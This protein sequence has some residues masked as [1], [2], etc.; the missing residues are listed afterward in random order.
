MLTMLTAL[1]ISG[2]AIYYS[3]AGLVAIFA[4]AAIPII[5]MGGILEVSKLVSAVWLHRYWTEAPRWLRYYLLGAVIVLM[6]ITSMGIFGFLSKAHIEQSG[7][8]KEITARLEQLDSELEDRTNTVNEREARIKSLS[9]SGTS[10]QSSLQSQIDIEEDRIDSSYDRIRPL[11]N[12]QNGIIQ[13][14]LGLYRESIQQIDNDV[15]TLQAYIDNNLIEKAQAFIG[16]KADGKYGLK[17]AEAFTEYQ[18]KQSIERQRLVTKV[19]EAGSAS[20]VI[21]A[22]DEI[23]R[24]RASAERQII[25]SEELISQYQTRLQTTVAENN[26]TDLIADHNKIINLAKEESFDLV[27]EKYKLEHQARKLAI[28]VGPV[29]YIAEL[30]YGKETSNHILAESVRWVIIILIFVFDPLA[31]I[32]LIASQYSLKMVNP[33]YMSVFDLSPMRPKEEEVVE[34][35]PLPKKKDDKP[36]PKKEPVEPKPPEDEHTQEWINQNLHKQQLP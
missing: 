6:F 4:G 9:L 19:E 18:S 20:E 34:L 15:S 28:E 5:I 29:K 11:I 16:V 17:T 7:V 10:G 1:S 3:V 30:I 8:G 14:Y 22:R 23:T 31:V 26:V 24:L 35:K 2:V 21:A 36:E 27:Q 32:L 25:K 12:E 13:N 33:N